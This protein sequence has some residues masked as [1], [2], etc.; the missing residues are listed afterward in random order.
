MQ[1]MHT[2]NKG[3]KVIYNT[4]ILHQMKHGDESV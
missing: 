3:L 4:T 2:A 1:I